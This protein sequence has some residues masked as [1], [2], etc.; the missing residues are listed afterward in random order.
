MKERENNKDLESFLEELREQAV[1]GDFGV[2]ALLNEVRKA[3]KKCEEF[4]NTESN[5][6]KDIEFIQALMRFAANQ[7]SLAFLT[8]YFGEQK[9]EEEVQAIFKSLL[10]RE[11]EELKLS[12]N[13]HKASIQFYQYEL[14]R[15]ERYR[16]DIEEAISRNYPNLK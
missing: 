11:L 15:N 4:R 16:T 8:P 13:H 7:P 2:D 5:Q 12:A 10:L 6:P 3:A 14:K 9:S 1:A